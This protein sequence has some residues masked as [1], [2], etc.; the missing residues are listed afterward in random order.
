MNEETLFHLALEKPAGERPAFLAE[1]CRDD[2]ALR[3]RL[4]VLLAAH[5]SPGSFL[6]GP[7]LDGPAVA[8][9]RPD[10]PTDEGGPTP[11]GADPSR[12]PPAGEEPGSQVGPYILL[13][14][15]GEGGMGSVFLA[16]QARPVRRQVA[17]KVIKPGLDSRQVI[18]RFEA[19]RQALALMDHPNIAKVL[20]AGTTDSGRPFFVMELVPGV[21]LTNYCDEQ[22]LT[23]RRRLEL[24]VPV[25]RAVQHAHQKGVIH[26]DLKPSNVL[27]ALYDGRPAPK[28]IDFG[29]AKATGPALTERTLQ[30]ELG[31]VV[32]T[33]EYM[34]PEQA[35]LGQLDIDT[36]SDVYALGV[37][38]YEL[39]TGT[40]PLDR[41]RLRDEGLLGLLRAIR[42][43]EPPR[44]SARLGATPEL[45]SVASRR[46]LE[47]R[48]LSGLVRGELDWIVMKCLEKDRDRRYESADAL[49]LDVERYLRDEAV[50]ACP[51]SGTYRLRKLVWRNKGAVLAAALVVVVLVAGIIG[52]TWE[53]VHATDAEAAALAE[54]KR[55]DEALAEKD[56]AL[57]QA[58]FERGR[59]IR[60]EGEAKDDR[61]RAVGAEADTS[62]FAKFLVE[63]VLAA[64]RPKDVQGGLG[65]DVKL[66]DALAAVEGRVGTVFAGRPKAE[67]TARH[68]LGVTWRNLGQYAKAEAHLRRAV[69]LRR[70]ELGPDALDTLS[71]CNSLAVT[72]QQ[73][74]RV[75]EALPLFEDTLRREGAVR[76]ADHP[77]VLE[78]LHNLASA[79][80]EDGQPERAVSLHRRALGLRRARFGDADAD[81]LSS[82]NGLGLAY[83]GEH[84]WERAVPLL[85]A[86]LDGRRTVLGPE[87]SH[88][89]AS[90]SNLGVAYAE[91]EQP[92]KAIPL[93]TEALEKRKAVLGLDHP[94]TVQ[95]MS[96]L[97]A[98]YQTAGRPDEAIPLFQ[99]AL[100]KHKVDPGPDHIQT[101][102]AMGKL[103]AAYRDA[104]RF[105]DALRLLDETL[106]RAAATAGPDDALAVRTRQHIQLTRALKGQMEQYERARAAR[107]PDDRDTLA[108]R[109]Q[110]G[111]LLRR[112]LSLRAAEEHLRAV[113]EGRLRT[114]GP[115][116]TDTVLV[117]TDVGVA[118]VDLHRYAEAEPYLRRSLAAFAKTRPD[119]WMRFSLMSVLGECL[120]GQHKYD[121]AEALLLEGFDGL[122]RR[123][124]TIAEP[125]R[126]A[127][128]HAAAN[129]LV[130]L[131]RVWDKEDQAGAWRKERDAIW[132]A[133]KAK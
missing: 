20:D 7:A 122:K 71:S 89:L 67:A 49:A 107:G 11:P 77:T 32:G 100:E 37:L 8:D 93:F 60:A 64:A 30:T 84:N 73:A 25:C 101:L 50:Q 94:I 38:L 3:R 53:M 87:H 41:G 103:A 18:T 86:A 5:D 121:E 116:D 59:A 15:I 133:G 2:E 120:A 99:Q 110:V 96:N 27:V 44:P 65:V 92:D 55:K 54:G 124:S 26:R 63:D 66:V 31:S 129:R 85:Q 91:M 56:V 80:V 4:E 123:E 9:T 57:R 106:T 75:R 112:L 40:T 21:P 90:L 70:Q 97:A 82:L 79:Y 118:L 23:V 62:A 19:E 58:V 13:R 17:L 69:E 10:L 74:G 35:D 128:L 51:P 132:A 83:L 42:E 47:P 16:E 131:Y 114:L 36:R 22:R 78:V 46:G 61:D 125:G 98:A 28:V 127:H 117:Q 111:Y 39:L 14:P 95:S 52:T 43:E 12:P 88:T 45:P 29:V 104:G 1:A 76:G 102:G 109:A 68:A 33:L 130:R 105:D 6:Q 115:E 108:K 119:S 34:S 81:T 72:V 113:Y 126:S 48:K 24:F